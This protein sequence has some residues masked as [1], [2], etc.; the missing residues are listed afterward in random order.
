MCSEGI[1]GMAFCCFLKER[2]A[3]GEQRVRE[4]TPSGEGGSLGLVS[5]VHHLG[6]FRSL[7]L[8]GHS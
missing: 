5:D 6:Y 7:F 4:R 1:D 3:K 8:N 2:M